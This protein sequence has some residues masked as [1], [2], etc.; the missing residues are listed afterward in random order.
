MPGLGVDLQHVEPVEAGPAV[1]VAEIGTADAGAAQGLVGQQRQAQALVIDR[2]RHVCRHL[3]HRLAV[4]VLRRVVV[5]SLIGHDLG[6]RE[7]P[8]AHHRHGQLAPGDVAFH[9]RPVAEHPGV[10]VDARCVVARHDDADADAGTLIHRL[11]HIGR[12]DRMTG[13]DV[14]AVDHHPMRRRHADGPQHPL[15]DLLVHRQRRGHDTGMGVGDLQH[16]ENALDDPV[17]AALA[18]QRVEHHVGRRSQGVQQGRQVA[19]DIDAGHLIAGLLQR[20]GAVA[21]GDQADLPFRGPAAHQQGDVLAGFHAV[22]LSHDR[23]RFPA[24]RRSGGFPSATRCRACREP[25]RGPSRP[26]SPDRR[27]WHRRC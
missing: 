16:L 5:E 20:L 2:L 1:V 6:D 27:R 23:P 7:R 19:A 10:L 22:A 17:L 4:G 18:V 13:Q 12:I 8:V 24:A 15:G 14:V 25:G 3:V 9:Q 11:D 21:A 26:A